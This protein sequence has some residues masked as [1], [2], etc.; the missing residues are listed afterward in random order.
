M[1]LAAALLLA[2]A[3][4]PLAGGR[5]SRLGD[6]RLRGAWLVVAGAG[7]QMLVSPLGPAGLDTEVAAGLHAA[8]Y[9]ALGAFVVANRRV[10]GL[11]VVGLG[12]AANFA[13]IALN[14]GVMPATRAALASAGLRPG[15]A[16]VDPPGGGGGRFLNSD[17][18][19]DARLPFLGDVFAV[20][21]SWPLAT[22]F[23]AGDVLV[24]LGAAILM[25]RVCGSRLARPRSRARR[26]EGG[27]GPD[28]LTAIEVS[29]DETPSVGS[30]R[31][32]VGSQRGLPADWG[33]GIRTP[34]SGTKTRRPAS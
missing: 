9:G 17:Y 25:H 30:Q 19:A 34:V 1:L 5:L 10:P 33:G 15:Q 16:A 31:S 4:V 7:L 23:S 18:V 14:G 22:V 26:G 6:L 24:V 32:S 27:T 21:A 28:L 29:T 12:G 13:A 11:A 20:P 3:T 8:S 2:L